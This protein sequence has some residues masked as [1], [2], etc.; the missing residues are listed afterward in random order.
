MHVPPC[1]G[2]CGRRSALALRAKSVGG[3][4]RNDG[5]GPAV[6]WIYA[7]IGGGCAS[8]SPAPPRCAPGARKA[9]MTSLTTSPAWRAC[10]TVALMQYGWFVLGMV[11]RHSRRAAVMLVRVGCI[12]LVSKSL[13]ASQHCIGSAPVVARR[14][15]HGAFVGTWAHVR[16]R[17]TVGVDSLDSKLPPQP[18]SDQVQE[19]PL[20]R[21]VCPST[22]RLF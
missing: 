14:E 11:H 15:A 8:S 9:C 21:D 6:W 2:G 4:G 20:K 1:G 22:P 5:A 7:F 10:K 19:L 13:L 3:G 17:V 16:W 12:T 18:L